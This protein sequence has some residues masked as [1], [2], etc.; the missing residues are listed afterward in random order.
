MK[1]KDLMPIYMYMH[2]QPA[3][4]LSSMHA[5]ICAYNYRWRLVIHGCIDG[6]SRLITYLR[7]STNNRAETV[8]NCFVE[9]VAEL[10]L[11]SRVRC[12]MGV[13][14]RLV[15]LYMLCHP[16][17]GPGRGSVI[18]G[19]SVHN[20]RIERLWRDVF[21]GVLC[22]YRDLFYH[23]ECNGV[24]NPDNDIH[25]FCLHYVFLPRLQARL[26]KWRHAWNC[27]RIRTA[28]GHSPQQ[29]WSIGLYQL[30]ARG[31]QIPQECDVDMFE[32]L[33]EVRSILFC[34]QS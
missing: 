15:S 7:C 2:V 8:L 34:M 28:N 5:Y 24:L 32:N 19:K 23:L 29:L 12:D 26:Q 3:S 21:T 13:E 9:A 27:H 30:F 1:C 14:N 10:G 22:H 17:R 4:Y 16:L 6:Y 31:L 20:Q 33:S 18:V 25:I 11:P